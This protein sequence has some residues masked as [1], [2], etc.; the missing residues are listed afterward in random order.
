MEVYEYPGYRCGPCP[1]GL[2]GNGTHCTD[3]NEVGR[4]QSERTQQVVGRELAEAQEGGVNVGLKQRSLGFRRSW[5]PERCEK[6][7]RQRSEAEKD[8]AT[9]ARCWGSGRGN[10]RWLVRMEPRARLGAGLRAQ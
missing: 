5:R 7:G 3:I 6:G 4:V 10:L 1:P 2:Q 8:R 9:Q